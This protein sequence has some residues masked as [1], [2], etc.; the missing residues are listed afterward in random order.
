MSKNNEEK[1]PVGSP[2]FYKTPEEL[3]KKILQYFKNGYRKVKRKVK[4]EKGRWVEIEVPKITI[5][6]LVIYLGFADRTSFYDYEKKKK[7]AYTIKKARTF[8]EREYEEQLD[9]NPVGAIFALKN[10]GWTD[11][12]EREIYGKGGGSIN[13]ISHI[14]RPDDK[15]N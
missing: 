11:K 7:F 9:I 4:G 8:I 5:T 2:P 10:F 12:A 13:I 1:N 6:D 3:Q 14:P 15:D